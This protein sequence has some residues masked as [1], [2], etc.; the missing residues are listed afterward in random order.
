MN[1]ALIQHSED[2]VDHDQRGQNQQSLAGERVF[3]GGGG[4]LE[5]GLHGGGKVHSVGYFVDG[6]NGVAERDSR[7]KVEG[8]GDGGKL[9]L[10]VDG[11]GFGRG[12][13]TAESA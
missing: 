2:D 12:F 7:S 11:E 3:K 13:V 9:S 8:D 4:A 6:A 10:M 1:E 5:V